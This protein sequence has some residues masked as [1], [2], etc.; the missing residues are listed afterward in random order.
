VA[1]RGQSSVDHLFGALQPANVP[2]NWIKRRL[3]L[4]WDIPVNAVRGERH[5]QDVISKLPGVRRGLVDKVR[6]E[7]VAV[8]MI[9]EPDNSEDRFA[10]RAV[11]AGS[12]VGYLSRECASVLAPQADAAGATSWG[13]CGAVVGG[14]P[15]ATM[16]GTPLAGPPI[17]GRS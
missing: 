11:V 5:H 4:Q 13:I 15:G 3:W 6:L 10:C 1:D 2:P 17:D 16:Y 12:L 8:D 14:S 7:P 9:R